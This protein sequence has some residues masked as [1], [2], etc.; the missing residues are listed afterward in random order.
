MRRTIV[1]LTTIALTLLVASG[2]ALAA[3]RTEA[4]L[5]RRGGKQTPRPSPLRNSPKFVIGMQRPSKNKDSPFE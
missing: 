2:V 5:S 1:L 4:P 3:A